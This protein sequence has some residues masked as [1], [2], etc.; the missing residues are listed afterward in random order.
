MSQPESESNDK[1]SQT[2]PDLKV[3]LSPQEA[4]NDSQTAKIDQKE[5]SDGNFEFVDCFLTFVQVVAMIMYIAWFQSDGGW[6]PIIGLTL[7][8]TFIEGIIQARATTHRQI[9]RKLGIVIPIYLFSFFVIGVIFF[10]RYEIFTST[11][12]PI[13]TQPVSEVSSMILY[14]TFGG[15]ALCGIEQSPNNYRLNFSVQNATYSF[16]DFDKGDTDTCYCLD[17]TTSENLPSV[18]EPSHTQVVEQS[19]ATWRTSSFALNRGSITLITCDSV[20]SDNI[21]QICEQTGE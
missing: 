14:R 18:C 10:V 5:Q 2:I 11:T 8:I 21:I 3:S 16:S 17:F 7:T 15:I 20:K 4:G 13:T 1:V 6:E 9:K 19:D 12:D